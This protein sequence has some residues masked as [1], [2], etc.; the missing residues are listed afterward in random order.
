MPEIILFCFVPAFRAGHGI[1]VVNE[2][3]AF[4]FGAKVF[5]L[6]VHVYEIAHVSSGKWSS[7]A[8]MQSFKMTAQA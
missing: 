2:G 1:V 7:T 4:A 3:I 5:L 6:D 8:F